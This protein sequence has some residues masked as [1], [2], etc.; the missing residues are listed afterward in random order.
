VKDV[1]KQ[2]RV[3]RLDFDQRLA[4]NRDATLMLEL[5]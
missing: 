3:A 5:V 1:E 4:A 2:W